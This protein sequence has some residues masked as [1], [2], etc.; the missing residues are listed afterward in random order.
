M[1]TNPESE[2]SLLP[3]RIEDDPV[4]AWMVA[5]VFVP[6]PNP[7]AAAMRALEDELVEQWR[8]EIRERRDRPVRELQ[9][10]IRKWQAWKKSQAAQ[11]Q[12]GRGQGDAQ[13]ADTT[14]FAK[15]DKAK[16]A[17]RKG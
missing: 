8:Q 15:G 12:G 9:E 17:S 7:A 13:D 1:T 5:H 4:L 3:D 10:R 2:H 11:G 16:R 6:P 14:P